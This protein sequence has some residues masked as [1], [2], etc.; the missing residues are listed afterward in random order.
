MF[1]VGLLTWWYGAGWKKFGQILINK[2]TVTEDFFS[3]DMLLGSIFAPFKQ[4]SATSG[5][6]GTLQMK[7]QAWFDKQFSRL[8]GAI[9]RLLLIIVGAGWLLLQMTIDI[10]LMILWP[11]LPILPVIGL[12]AAIGGLLL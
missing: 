10:V 2:L 8:I 5:S 11:V 3:I 1:I 6:G 12:I 9:I 7:L 4:I